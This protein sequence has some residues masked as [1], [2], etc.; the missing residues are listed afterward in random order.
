MICPACHAESDDGKD[1]CPNCGQS[2][3]GHALGPGTVVAGRYEIL[4]TLGRGGMGIVFEA[5][6]HSLEETVALKMLR[7]DVARAPDLERRFRSEIK[8]ARRVRHRNV[9]GIHEYGEDGPLRYIAMERVEGTDL[10]AWLRAKGA[11][12]AADAYDVAIQLTQGLEAI[13]EAGIVHRDLKTS[14]VMR[15]RHGIVRL[16]DFGIAKQLGGEATLGGLG[17]GRILGTPEY[18]SPEQARGETLDFRGDL[19]SLGV[20]IYEIFTGHVPFH[21]GTPLATIFM[22]L[23]QPPVLEGPEA[24]GIPA[25]MVPVLARALAKDPAGRF[26]S[27]HELGEAIESARNPSVG[28]ES[29]NDVPTVL[30]HEAMTDIGLTVATPVPA[31]TL[32]PWRS[33]VAKTAADEAAAPTMLV[34]PRRIAARTVWPW[35]AAATVLLAILAGGTGVVVRG[36]L[37]SRE[38]D[39]SGQASQAQASPAP[40][41]RSAAPAAQTRAAAKG[42]DDPGGPWSNVPPLERPWGAIST[43]PPQAPTPLPPIP[44]G[45][46]AS[47]VQRPVAVQRPI[48][49]QR[50]VPEPR[51][52]SDEGPG[53]LRLDIT[54]WALVTIDD[55]EVGTTPLRPIPL[56]SGR[57]SVRLTHPDYQ[58]LQR[59][60]QIRPGETTRLEIDLAW[61]AVP[62]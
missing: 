30:L 32:R 18:M 16:M 14:N 29:P 56:A 47:A 28:G 27:A 35:L 31:P 61:E 44:A 8:L 62:K 24:A 37:A 43:E 51:P 55:A 5:R 33:D 11:L 38:A 10:K 54:P 23:E 12:P 42:A 6:D 48:V 21:A 4:G 1:V 9:C 40:E 15:D 41:Q 34:A 22:A 57:H 7:A 60:I 17:H 45:R 52:A 19:Y 50:P 53:F 2:L 46:D 13:H 49:E 36:L 39:P 20:V 58:P 25:S 3:R 26:A 59:K